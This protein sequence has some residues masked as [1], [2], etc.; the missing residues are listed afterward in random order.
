MHIWYIHHYGGG[1]RVG[2]YHRPYELARAWQRQGHSATVFIAGFHHLLER[3]TSPEPEFEV[4]GVRYVSVPA[5]PY[6]RNGMSRLF[7]MWDFTKNLY[8]VGRRYG[9]DLPAPDAVI[10]SSPHPFTVFPAHGLAKRHGAKFVYEIRDI[11][12]LSITEIQGTSPL[13][14]FVMLCGLA[15]RFAVRKAD[16]V[17][18]VLPWVGR[19]L[20][21]R[22]YRDTPFVWVPNGTGAAGSPPEASL[23]SE[24]AS[25]AAAKLEEWRSRGR[26]CIIYTGAIGKPNALDQLL[27]GLAHGKSRGEENRFGVLIVGKGEQLETLR[28][29]AHDNGLSDIHFSGPVPKSDALALL[30]QADIGY[31][32]LRNIEALFGYGISP[33]KIVDYFNAALPV[34]LPIQPCGDPVSES[35]GGVARR[36][37]TPED[38]WNGLSELAR[39]SPEQRH[40]MGIKGQEY[41]AREYDYDRI[42]RR[43]VEAIAA[44]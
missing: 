21:D 23:V 44:A 5:R 4:D 31:A 22:G 25:A 36:S 27:Q 42:A 20:A 7:N 39:M 16:L 34:F 35:G 10:A 13:H 28:S 32:G 8:A 9:R 38:I 29:F 17:A 3:D 43:Y 2:S 14:P 15:E 37:E 33:N 26:V 1:P 18:S 24:E 6:A 40:A 12:P 11:W 41:I 19:Y 30:T